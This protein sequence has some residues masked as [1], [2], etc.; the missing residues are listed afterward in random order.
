MAY[1]C[2]HTPDTEDVINCKVCCNRVK[3][4]LRARNKHNYIPGKRVFKCGHTDETATLGCVV[5]CHRSIARFKW[6]EDDK[7]R[8]ENLNPKYPYWKARAP[9]FKKKNRPMREI[10]I[11]RIKVQE[12]WSNDPE[13]D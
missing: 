1:T 9:R 8:S 6:K 11:G 5:C 2:G 7:R 4:R 12:D 3:C 13:N 10:R